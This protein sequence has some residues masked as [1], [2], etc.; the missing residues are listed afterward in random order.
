MIARDS[1][2]WGMPSRIYSAGQVVGYSYTSDGAC[3]TWTIH[4]VLWQNARTTDLGFS[5]TGTTVSTAFVTKHLKVAFANAIIL[6]AG[7]SVK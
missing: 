5:P 4:G 1:E 3:V 6:D 7:V 2:K